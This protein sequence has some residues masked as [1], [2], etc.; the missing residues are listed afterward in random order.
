MKKVLFVATVYKFLN[1][2]KNDMSILREKGYEIHS[3]TN[4]YESE[5]LKDDG[6]LDNYID[7]KHQIN[8]GRSPFSKNTIVAYKE[9][10]K[11]LEEQKYDIIHCHTP[12]AAAILRLAS[13]KYRKNGLKVI[14]T[15]HGFHFHRK[16]SI[17]Q[18]LIF[19]PI[20][21][22][23]SMWTDMIITINQ[24]DYNLS[25]KL[26]SKEKKYIP[27]VGVDV[28]AISDKKVN[29]HQ[30]RE[31]YNIPENAFVILSIGELSDR[32][33][34][35]V[36]IKALS[37]INKSDI[38]YVICGTGKL[39][40][41]LIEL[42]KELKISHNVIFT[43]KLEHDQVVDLCHACDIGALPSRIEGLGLAGIEILSAGKP[44][45]ASNIHGIVDYAIDG[46]T[47]F[48]NSPDDVDGFSKSILNLQ[49]NKF[50]YD[51]CSMNAIEYASKFDIKETDKFMREYYRIIEDMK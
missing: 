31:R 41:E 3:A 29:I 21:Y 5:W 6:S 43:G 16:S 28:K 39:E 45:V 26:K 36:I 25:L 22:I 11:L 1:F 37:R 42:S 4:M 38:Y 2:E 50:V 46:K 32:K 7:T 47:G 34:H 23:T 48:T 20:E 17:L 24:E 13:K 14:Y 12:V 49:N 18:W 33:N 44:I 15:C 40:N 30:V 8:F 19:Y 10:Q 35:K 9:I 51:T 27:G